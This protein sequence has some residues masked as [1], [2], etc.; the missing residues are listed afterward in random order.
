MKDWIE[1]HDLRVATRLGITEQERRDPQGV[2]VTLRF[3]VDS[4]L[5]GCTDD[6]K[7]TTNYHAVADRLL[8]LGRRSSCALVERFAESVAEVCLRDFG[9][10]RVQ[11]RVMK[12]TALREARAVGILIDRAQSDLAEPG[13]PPP[14]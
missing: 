11:V 10:T 5:P 9:T 14:R 12:E 4:R 13:S 2:L 8:Q 7:D 6:L 3:L 1:I